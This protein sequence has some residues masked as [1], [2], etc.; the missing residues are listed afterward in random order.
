ML[1][2]MKMMTIIVVL[3][4]L[5]LSSS[6]AAYAYYGGYLGGIPRTYRIYNEKMRAYKEGNMTRDEFIENVIP[7][8]C[9]PD[10]ARVLI[11]LTTENTDQLEAILAV[12]GNA[13]FDNE[14]PKTPEGEKDKE[15]LEMMLCKI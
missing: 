9:K 15:L 14:Y 12:Q 10:N 7:W 2:K 8:M 1:N 11:K 6:V 5:S 4:I 3:I 13:G